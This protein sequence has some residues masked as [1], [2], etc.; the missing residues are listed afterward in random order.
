MHLWVWAVTSSQLRY[1]DIEQVVLDGESEKPEDR[2]VA[3]LVY[4]G[5]V[6]FSVPQ[7]SHM[8]I[9]IVQPLLLTLPQ[10]HA[11]LHKSNFKV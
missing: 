11:N 9:G 4:S 3:T 10:I 7:F 2:F 8:F 5:Q 1:D 6:I